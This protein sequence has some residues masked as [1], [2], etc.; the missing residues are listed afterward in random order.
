M[1]S[2]KKQ[3]PIILTTLSLAAILLH[4]LPFFDNLGHKNL[5]LFFI[6]IIGGMPFIG[7]IIIKIYHKNFGAD[8]LA[9]IALI[10]SITTEQYLAANL[11]I[12]MVASGQ[13]LEIYASR[14]ASFALEALAKRVPSIAHRRIAGVITDIALNQIAIG[15]EIVIYPHQTCPVDGVIIEGSGSMDESYLTGEPY[16][17][18][19]TLGSLVLSGAINQDNL[20]VVRAEKV[21]QDSRYAKIM[22]VM[23]EA[24]E[25][26][27]QITRLADE[28]GAIFTPIALIFAASAW[29]FSG[30]ILRFVAVLTVATPC[31]LLIAIPIC[32]VG[33]ISLSAKR[34]IIIK[35]PTVLEKLPT[36]S[37]AIFDK[38]GT[39]TYGEPNLTEIIAAQGFNADDILQ[40]T[41]SLERYSRHPLA[42][43][44]AKAALQKNLKLLDALEVAERAGKGLR[45]IVANQEIIVTN[46]KKA[47]QQNPQLASSIAISDSGLECVILIDQKY[48]ATLRFHDAP[49]ADSHSFINH[50]G[51]EHNF[52]KIILL[53]G[54][55]ESEVNYLATLLDI[56]QTYASQSPEQKLQFVKNETALAP[57]LFMGDGINDAPAL[58]AATVGLAF[59]QHNNITSEAAGA[60]ILD[61][62]LTK[63]DELIHISIA[64][65]KIALQSAIG[66]MALSLIGMG[67]AAAGTISP[68]QGALLQEIIDVAAILNALRITW[69]NLGCSDLKK[70]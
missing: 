7:Q 44:I 51:P 12:F 53:S 46:R 2:I 52:T 4:L 3:W 49:R 47:L 30:D 16:Q 58:T 70:I 29:Y 45:G 41:A 25:R 56:K 21:P 64:M 28:I 50:L 69:Q 10:G 42:S 13:S 61:N 27:P 54:D 15:D 38:T 19:K 62:T 37:T 8:L 65:R 39:L 18:L 32:V 5:P 1:N 31:P 23:Q 6:I 34:G 57:T 59:G 36:C 43:A 40:K 68:T 9:A 55:R 35:D 67:F 33:A 17:I 22:Q 48:A 66:G 14:K 24:E 26:K 20:V 63:V 60:V 11:I